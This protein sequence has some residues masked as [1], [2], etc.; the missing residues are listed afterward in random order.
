MKHFTNHLQKQETKKKYSL[1]FLQHFFSLNNLPHKHKLACNSQE[2]VLALGVKSTHETNIHKCVYMY[3]HILF[4]IF[5]YFLIRCIRCKFLD[6][7]KGNS[8]P[9]QSSYLLCVCFSL[10][11]AIIFC[12]ISVAENRNVKMLNMCKKFL[13]DTNVKEI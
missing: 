1:Y 9:S 8:E 5:I 2:Q 4:Y 10:I 7:N 6:G 11:Q 13:L 12:F 3:K